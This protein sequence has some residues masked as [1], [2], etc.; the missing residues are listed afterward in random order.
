MGSSK[1]DFMVDCMITAGELNE[2]GNKFIDNDL[3]VVEVAKHNIPYSEFLEWRNSFE[4]LRRIQELERIGR[5]RF[6]ADYW[7]KYRVCHF[8]TTPKED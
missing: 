4:C 2:T 8:C 7:M 6:G 1:D 5:E 3:K